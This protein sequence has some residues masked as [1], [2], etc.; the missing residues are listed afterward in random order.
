MYSS[1]REPP[2][3]LPLSPLVLN[4]HPTSLISASARHKSQIKNKFS[5]LR[6][7]TDYT[8]SAK[9]IRSVYYP[10]TRSDTI[11]YR[12]VS[13]PIINEIIY[14]FTHLHSARS[15]HIVTPFV[16][17][18]ISSRRM[19][20]GQSSWRSRCLSWRLPTSLSSRWIVTLTARLS[21]WLRCYPGASRRSRCLSWRLPTSLSSRWIVTLT[22]RLSW[23]LRCYPGA[24]RRHVTRLWS[25]W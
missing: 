23:W 8:V 20:H 12:T 16:T 11:R 19:H 3:P 18:T 24:S 21:W 22:T 17:A 5:S 13:W 1:R 7:S 10:N 9:T 4:K 2:A 14:T 6:N 15:H 25:C